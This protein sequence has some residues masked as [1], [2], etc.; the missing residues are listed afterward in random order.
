MEINKYNGADKYLSNILGKFPVAIDSVL[1]YIP[2]LGIIHTILRKNS[3]SFKP[4]SVTSPI[5]ADNPYT[6]WVRD[7]DEEEW[8]RQHDVMYSNTLLDKKWKQILVL[9]RYSY[10]EDEIGTIYVI[11]TQTKAMLRQGCPK[12][13]AACMTWPS[14][15]TLK[16]WQIGLTGIAVFLS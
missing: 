11:Q 3:V 13:F 10:G 16:L 2:E 12:I 9:D 4:K 7:D 5:G 1:C 14:L 6:A 8:K 15:R